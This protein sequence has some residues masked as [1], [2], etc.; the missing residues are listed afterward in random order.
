MVIKIIKKAAACKTKCKC[1]FVPVKPAYDYYKANVMKL[2]ALLGAPSKEQEWER[3]YTEHLFLAL[4]EIVK[5]HNLDTDLKEELISLKNYRLITQIICEA[6]LFGISLYLPADIRKHLRV[7]VPIEITNISQEQQKSLLT[8]GFDSLVPL[9]EHKCLAAHLSLES[10]ELQFLYVAFLLENEELVKKCDKLFSREHIFRN[11]MVLKGLKHTSELSVAIHEKLLSN[12]STSGGFEM[13]CRMLV[14]KVE[15]W[16]SSEV[17]AKICAAKGH[18]L[19][20]YSH[21]LA[22]IL[23]FLK[24][25]IFVVDQDHFIPVCVNCLKMLHQNEKV[26]LKVEQQLLKWLE[27][28]EDLNLIGAIACSSGEYHNLLQITSACFGGNPI[29]ALPSEILM[30]HLSTLYSLYC[31]TPSNDKCSK[32]ALQTILHHILKNR[33]DL[34]ECVEKFLGGQE[35]KLELRYSKDSQTPLLVIGDVK[36]FDPG[37]IILVK[38]TGNTLL[39]Y[40]VLIILLKMFETESKGSGDLL[41]VEQLGDFLSVKFRRNLLILEALQEL[42]SFKS[43]HTQLKENPTPILEFLDSLLKKY[44]EKRTFDIE[45]IQLLLTILAEILPDSKNLQQIVSKHDKL[46]E[47][48]KAQLRLISPSNNKFAEAI[49]L[50]ARSEP[51]LRVNGTIQLIDLLNKKDT[52]TCANRFKILAVAIQNLKDVESYAYLNTIRLLLALANLIEAE[53][54]DAVL[55]EFKNESNDV[56]YRLKV[57]EV[58]IK[59]TEALGPTIYKYK[60]ELIDCFL[61]GCVNNKNELRA[62]SFYHLGAFCK[63]LTFQVHNFFNEMLTVV[64]QTLQMDEY[65]PARRAAVLLLNQLLQGMDNILDFQ[66]LLLPVYRTLKNVIETD[67]D[68]VTRM[69]AAL[70][71]ETLN[72]ATKEFLNPQQKIEF[73]LKIS[74]V[75]E[76][77]QIDVKYK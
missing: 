74:G 75:K 27:D 47:E 30:P 25:S 36:R 63:I 29:V 49:D 45:S 42:I 16:R 5:N 46:P 38:E 68:D 55:N 59:V 2:E 17:I 54:I 20:F 57:A 58:I 62:S 1:F 53:T 3:K 43:L 9:L 35:T 31:L 50:T 19:K 28:L 40:K 4:H 12:L 14:N 24:I 13:L 32:S 23:K 7:P 41:D 66:E 26:R 11:L 71:L 77:T 61:N 10:V 15:P 39:M 22:E 21:I 52:E 70:G 73:K 51:H 6:A 64:H 18:S 76:A 37:L 67:Q 69:Q 33:E 48:I 72:K 44:L 56:D 8:L 65:K 34:T 60:R